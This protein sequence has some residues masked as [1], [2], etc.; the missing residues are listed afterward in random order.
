MV[1][2][3]AP[4]DVCRCFC[5][6]VVFLKINS[7]ILFLDSWVDLTRNFPQSPDRITPLPNEDYIK[8][9]KEAA[10]E[11]NASSARVSRASSRLASYHTT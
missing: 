1:T 10:R 7:P 5:I 11:S 6:K 3:S 4:P 8:L 9:L 2:A